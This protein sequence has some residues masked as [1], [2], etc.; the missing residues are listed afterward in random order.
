MWGITEL[1]GFR[2]GAG[3]TGAIVVPV[4][5]QTHMWPIGGHHLSMLSPPPKAEGWDHN[6]LVESGCAYHL[7]D[8]LGSCAPPEL[9][10]HC[11]GHP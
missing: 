7:A 8:A 6:G 11:L 9:V 2:A 10:L 5:S 3:R 4:W 1:C